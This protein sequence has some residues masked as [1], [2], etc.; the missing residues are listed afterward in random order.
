[1]APWLPTRNQNRGLRC[2]AN[3]LTGKGVAQSQRHSYLGNSLL[4]MALSLCLLETVGLP[5]AVRVRV[6]TQPVNM[7][8][9]TPGSN[10]IT[11]LSTLSE[12]VALVQS[13]RYLGSGML[14]SHTGTLVT[15]AHIIQDSRPVTVYLSGREALPAQIISIYPQADVAILE[16]PSGH[17]PCLPLAHKLPNTDEPIWVLGLQTQSMIK[18]ILYESRIE[19]VVWSAN[20]TILLRLSLNLPPGYSGGPIVNKQGEVIG[21]IS[22]AMRQKSK[23]PAAPRFSILGS[24]LLFLVR[25]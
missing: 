22:A 18:G 16:L 24:S 17:Y 6:Q 21:I 11:S 8:C 9:A 1:M 12:P 14:V 4:S 10:G 25:K 15:A 20:R 23:A 7:D 5:S 13:G 2:K 19:E 3:G